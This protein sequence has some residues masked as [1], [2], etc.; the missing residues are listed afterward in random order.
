MPLILIIKLLLSF[1]WRFASCLVVVHWPAN[2]FVHH[3]HVG[4]LTP[5]TPPPSE[6]G[7]ERPF[8]LLLILHSPNLLLSLTARLGNHLPGVLR[9]LLVHGNE[10]EV[11]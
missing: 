9:E 5:A 8:L 1:H 2:N 4:L 3:W 6:V 10:V 11:V 7:H